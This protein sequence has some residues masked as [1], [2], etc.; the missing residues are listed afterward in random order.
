MRHIQYYL[1]DGFNSTIDDKNS[2]YHFTANPDVNIKTQSI[3]GDLTNSYHVTENIMTPIMINGDN[4]N[5]QFNR[6]LLRIYSS[7]ESNYETIKRNT[8]EIIKDFILSN[9]K[10]RDL[11]YRMNTINPIE[12]QMN[13]RG[14]NNSINNDNFYNFT[15]SYRSTGRDDMVTLEIMSHEVES[16]LLYLLIGSNNKIK[17]KYNIEKIIKFIIELSDAQ[18]VFDKKQE[19]L[20]I[21]PNIRYVLLQSLHNND[22]L[23]YDSDFNKS[24]LKNL[25][26]NSKDDTFGIVKINNDKEYSLAYLIISLFISNEVFEDEAYFNLC[27]LPAYN[28]KTVFGNLLDM[29]NNKQVKQ[30]ILNKGKGLFFIGESFR[31]L[32]H[33]LMVILYQLVLF[34]FIDYMSN[35]IINYNIKNPIDRKLFNDRDFQK[36]FI[37]LEENYSKEEIFEYFNN[38]LKELNE[39]VE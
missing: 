33:N 14:S 23:R 3:L 21:T 20:S 9:G 26:N 17:I 32:L 13:N 16:I 15:T 34:N 27:R 39:H 38:Y 37:I 2:I 8:T 25:I 11:I 29:N 5:I 19:F 24:N 7:F 31:S 12:R 6:N 28:P 35:K 36:F 10:I 4:R 1:E 18:K 22:R 30:N